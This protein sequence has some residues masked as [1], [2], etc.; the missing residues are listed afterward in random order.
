M[1]ARFQQKPMGTTRNKGVQGSWDQKA[2]DA[3]CVGPARDRYRALTL[4]VPSIGGTM[5]SMNSQLYLEHCDVPKETV[6]NETVRVATD[7]LDAIKKLQ[8]Q[9]S[10]QPGRH[11]SALKVLV[12]IFQEKSIGLDTMLRGEPQTS[13]SPT[14]PKN[15]RKIPRVHSRVMMNNTP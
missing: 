12:E 8:Y 11:T 1:N 4:S 15:L 7:L 6:V 9:E 2:I 10:V 5:L 14:R 3:W 13:G